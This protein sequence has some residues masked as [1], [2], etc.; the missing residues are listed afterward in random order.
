VLVQHFIEPVPDHTHKIGTVIAVPKKKTIEEH[1]SL[2]SK[3]A[4]S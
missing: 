3:A 1:C 4:A 2:A